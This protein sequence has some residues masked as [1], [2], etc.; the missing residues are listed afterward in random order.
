MC[1]GGLAVTICCYGALFYG[2]GAAGFDGA[3]EQELRLIKG[4]LVLGMLALAPAVYVPG[5]TWVQIFGGPFSGTLSAMFD[6]PGMTVCAF[7]YGS[8]PRWL[9]EGGWAL[10]FQYYCALGC[11]GLA[12]LSL[13]FLLEH[14]DQT[15]RSPFEEKKKAA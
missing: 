12:S 13:F 10:L 4:A 3:S 1:C 14:R 7:I 6:V 15:V 8:Y 5:N 2:R 11:V 9:E